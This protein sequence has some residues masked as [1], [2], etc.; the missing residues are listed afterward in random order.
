MTVHCIA[1]I[2]AELYDSLS[3]GLAGPLDRYLPR[4]WVDEALAAEDYHPRTS[5]FNPWVM[6]W[7]FI[8][9]VLDPDYSCRAALARIQAT[10]TR[11]GMPCLSPDTGGYCKAR[12]RLPEGMFSRLARRT[13]QTLEARADDV[14][15]WCN[16][17]VKTTD[18]TGVSMPDTRA[19]QKAYPQPSNQRPG[20]GFPALKLVGLFSMATGAALDFVLGNKH[21]H[22]LTLFRALRSNLLSGDVL[23]A[24]RAFCSY[25]EIAL[26]KK[27]GVDTVM[28][29]HQ[30]RSPVIRRP[31]VGIVHERYVRWDRPPRCPQGLR[32]ADYARLPA[33]LELREVTFRVDTPGFRTDRISV[34]TTLLD[35]DAYPAEALA[36]LYVCRW[37]VEVAFAHLKTTLGM[38]VVRGKSP[39]MVRKEVWTHMIAYN[40]VRMLIW[41]AAKHRGVEPERLSFK[42]TVQRLNSL[43]GLF[44]SVGASQR[45]EL[46]AMLLDTI[47][48]DAVPHR[49]NRYEPRVRK[50]RP[51]SYPLMTRP[52]AELK[53]L[54][55]A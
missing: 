53:A 25:A 28:R 50:R 37:G 2:A 34:V 5:I 31:R 49:P 19:N 40:L 9:Q 51:K 22:E 7:A 55:R 52:R 54:L 1:W 14:D 48:E 10:R 6:L 11:L 20:C 27:E 17:R 15:L 38:D 39:E 13:G 23:L 18:G 16:R 26:L 32:K 30:S 21:H 36:H 46:W 29:L 33:T 45:R 3:K 12:K 24:D 42:G 43:C 4:A 41:E 47:A 35:R 8:G 44:T